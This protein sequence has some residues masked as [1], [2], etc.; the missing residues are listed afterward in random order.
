MQKFVTFSQL[1]DWT[2]PGAETDLDLTRDVIA[3]LR[4]VILKVYKDVC[5]VV[6]APL[7]REIPADFDPL[8]D[9][10]QNE[11]VG[12]ILMDHDGN[13]RAAIA[14]PWPGGIVYFA[15][16]AWHEF[17]DISRLVPLDA[18]PVMAIEIPETRVARTITPEVVEIVAQ[19]K[20]QR[21]L[22]ADT[23]D[24]IP[25]GIEAALRSIMDR[26]AESGVIAIP[27]RPRS[28]TPTI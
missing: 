7:D 11:E 18:L 17:A 6:V 22:V 16:E 27:H 19:I 2:H 15:H 12:V 26:M 14:G 9:L 21:Q 5:Q 20:Q 8:Y 23:T 24:S 3:I 4:A 1:K 28:N 10:T 25:G 13:V